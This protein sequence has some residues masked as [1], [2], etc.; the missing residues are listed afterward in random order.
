MLS[1]GLWIYK[2]CGTAVVVI[3]DEHGDVEDF[4]WWNCGV[5]AGAGGVD[6][7]CMRLVRRL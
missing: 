6:D 1:I 4:L 3:S 5:D 7:A 2:G